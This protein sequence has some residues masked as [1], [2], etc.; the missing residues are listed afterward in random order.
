MA[1]KRAPTAQL[2]LKAILAADQQHGL[3]RNRTQAAARTKDLQGDWTA[4]EA[5]LCERLGKHAR[6]QGRC[7]HMLFARTSG[8]A[9]SPET[10]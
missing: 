6:G 5:L 2:A 1:G 8:D 10:I 3:S 7:A 9:C 4:I